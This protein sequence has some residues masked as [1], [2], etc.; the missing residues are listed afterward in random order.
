MY[1][2]L[3]VGLPVVALALAAT[4]GAAVAVDQ[5]PGRR[6]EVRPADLPPPYVSESVANGPEIVARPNDT[7]LVVP[8]G[9]S[10]APFAVGLAHPREFEVL[11]NG[12]VLLSEPRAGRITLLRDDDG[13]G[14]AETVTLFA[15]G[16]SAPYGMA[17]RGDWLYVA[18]LR[19]VW[20]LPYR[21]GASAA[22]GDAEPVTAVGALGGSRGHWSRS[23]VFHPDGDRFYVG[24]GSRGNL[25]EEALPRASVQEFALDKDGRA[26]ARRTFAAGLRNPVGIDFR[27]GSDD[28][29]AVVNER[30]GLGDRLVPDYLTWVGDGRFYGWPYA[31]IGPNPQPGFADRRPD[32][33]DL[34]TEPDVLFESHSAPIGLVFYDGEM[35]PESV[36]GDA[37]VALRGSWNRSDPTGY[38]VVRV[39]FE[40]GRPLGWY[41]IF[42]SGFWTGGERRAQ[43]WGRPTGLAV[44]ADGALLI[45]D[46]TGGTVWRVAFGE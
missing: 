27:P 42:A 20:R 46:D 9:Y 39:P 10:A 15:D 8:E 2:R 36:R 22:A 30:D 35:F 12:D 26:T 16:L 31:Y 38:M 5:P 11:P 44:A 34:T 7:A 18:D 28:L 3:I 17:L 6:L 45:A 29:Y 32:L 21:P 37:F 14:R 43:V 4:V 41:E 40:Q 1:D 25:D 24:V 23:L 33:V 19:A 13:D